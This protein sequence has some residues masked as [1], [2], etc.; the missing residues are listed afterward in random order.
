M[1]LCD[2]E[3]LM[4]QFFVRYNVSKLVE[5]YGVQELAELSSKSSKEGRIVINFTNPGFVV[6]EAMRGWTGLKMFMFKLMRA[7]LAR[8]TEVG[9]RTSVNA[10]AGGMDTHGQYLTDDRPSE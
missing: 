5:A 10:A 1:V 4:S 7:I 8:P 2:F 9:A 3:S 6:S